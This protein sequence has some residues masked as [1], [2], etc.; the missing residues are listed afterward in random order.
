MEG[1]GLYQ[2]GEAVKAIREGET[3]LDGRLPVNMD[4]GLKAKGHPVGATG[5][6]MAVELF[7]Q[8][9]GAA[10][11][12]QVKRQDTDLGIMLNFGAHGSTCV[13]NIFER[14]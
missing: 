13:V 9:R 14:R 12:R 5:T 7:T 10:G 2:P 3:N 11:K 6:A 8:M 1:L 4:G